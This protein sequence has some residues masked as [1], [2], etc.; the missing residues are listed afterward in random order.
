MGAVQDRIAATGA[1]WIR[2]DFSWDE[3]EP[4]DGQWSWSRYD[5]VVTSAAQRGLSVLPGLMGTPGW[6]GPAWNDIPGDPAAYAD[7]VAHV[8]GRYGPSGSFWAAHPELPRRPIEYFEIWNEPYYNQFS[9]NRIDPGRYAR[10]FKAAVIAGRAADA[11]AKFLIAAE[12]DVLPAGSSTWVHWADAMVAAVPDLG[13][14]IDVIAVHPYPKSHAPDEP[15]GSYPHDK[16][17][18]INTIRARFLALGID[19]PYWITEVGWSTCTANSE[20]CVSESQQAADY[21]KMFDL[22]RTQMSSYVQAVFVYHLFD[23]PAATPSDKED[24]YGL[25]QS[26]G[27]RTPAWDALRWFTFVHPSA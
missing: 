20:Y 8:V 3:I 12:T 10:L 7:Y 25:T 9:N 2:E 26:D 22:I 14:Y 24:W 16:F 1:G 4:Q 18:R 23:F 5:G 15:L 11:Q 27:G 21:T 17:L 19:Q 6:A 13:N